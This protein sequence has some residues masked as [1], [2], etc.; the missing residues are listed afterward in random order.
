MPD[1]LW[2]LLEYILQACVPVCIV[3]KHSNQ[4]S[5][6]SRMKSRKKPKKRKESGKNHLKTNSI[7]CFCTFVRAEEYMNT[8]MAK[9][10]APSAAAGRQ[11]ANIECKWNGP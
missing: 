9:A 6:R 5:P 2:K 7:I 11:I 4:T 3:C 10:N 8:D 1:T